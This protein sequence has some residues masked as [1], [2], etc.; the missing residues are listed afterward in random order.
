VPK[1]APSRVG[2]GLARSAP[3]VR[4]DR[5]AQAVARGCHLSTTENK[6]SR[7]K[8]FVSCRHESMPMAVASIGDSYC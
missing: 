5:V 1:G 2:E 4:H 3:I 8:N 6:W 7:G